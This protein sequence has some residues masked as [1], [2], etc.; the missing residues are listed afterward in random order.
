MTDYTKENHW[1]GLRADDDCPVPGKTLVELLLN[2]GTV[3]A[4]DKAE[5]WTWGAGDVAAFR[6]TREPRKAREWWV[7]IR[8]D[9]VIYATELQHQAASLGCPE[10]VHVRE[11]LPEGE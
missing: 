6:I 9:G 2:D 11:V 10:I 7:A 4:S 1:Y 8:D 3:T 5:N